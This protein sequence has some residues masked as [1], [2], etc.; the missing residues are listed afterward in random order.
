MKQKK[1]FAKKLNKK[2]PKNIELEN[3]CKNSPNLNS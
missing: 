3:Y 1:N 2:T